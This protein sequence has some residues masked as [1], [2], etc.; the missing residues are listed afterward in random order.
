M[1][2]TTGARAAEPLVL[3]EDRYFD[4][5]PAV[6]RV[7]R[8]L[9]EETRGLPLICPH[10][11]VDPTLLAEDRAFPEPTA[12]LLIP[13]HYIFRML[14]SQGV[15]MEAMGIPTRDG[16]KVE[17]DPRRIWQ[18]F[19][20]H[21]YL[22]RG[23]PTGAWLAHELHDVFG[24]RV[25][26]TGATGQRIYDEILEK[27]SS[28]EFRPR[29][30][31]DR[32]GIE[33]LA[34][35]DAATDSLEAH[36]KI[37]ESR[38]GGRVVPTF[39]PDALFRIALP[40][41]RDELARLSAAT[42][43]EVATY[44]DFI[45]ALEERR[46]YFRSL[47]ATAT[48]H[49]VVE[50]RTERLS[51]EEAARLFQRALRGE[52]TAADQASFEAHLLMEMARMSVE[53]GLVMQLHPGALRDH[54]ERV[55]NRFG[56][57]KGADIPVATEYTRNLRPLLNAYGNEPGFTL[58]L[59]TLDESTYARELAPLAGHYPALRLG[60]P[61]W[62]HDSI[63]GMK[64]FRERTTETAGIYNTAGFNDDT[65]AFC[66]IPAR[67]DVSRR[68]DANFLAGLVAR[69]VVDLGDARAMARALAYDLV[70]DTYRL[71]AATGA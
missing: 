47:G 31:F 55:F 27:L 48:D 58:V 22:F 40:G 10:G 46:A 67:H 15:P 35:T 53:D 44:A 6:R 25:K 41:W 49:G 13:D 37:R 56:L 26:L 52:A 29:A 57:D 54:N 62:F 21:F 66:S 38:W 61:W 18:L 4:P 14:Y 11:H 70:R 23:T 30:L 65:R 12:L 28:P 19:A 64:R 34:T 33:V 59:F 16:S 2:A 43:R 17:Q 36:R 50:P 20:D 32:F 69:H 63:E 39:R 5:D 3:H 45:A 9:Y 42:G 7:A 51:D 8:S 60:P 71:G 24:V 1:E 68:V